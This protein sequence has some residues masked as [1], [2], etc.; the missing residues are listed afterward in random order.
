MNFVPDYKLVPFGV[1][2]FEEC[3]DLLSVQ[4]SSANSIKSPI[5]IALDTSKNDFIEKERRHLSSLMYLPWNVVLVDRNN[6]EI[7]G[8]SLL[9]TKTDKSEKKLLADIMD[10]YL[11]SHFSN[12]YK[13]FRQSVMND[14]NKNN[15][16]KY[17][18][19]LY[20]CVN[21]KYASK[22]VPDILYS[23]QLILLRKFGYSY[24][25][26]SI[27]NEYAF[28]CDKRYF[29]NELIV[30][31]QVKYTKISDYLNIDYK[32][33]NNNKSK[34]LNQAIKIHPFRY[35]GHM[36]LSDTNE[37]LAKFINCYPNYQQEIKSF[38][39]KIFKPCHNINQPKSKL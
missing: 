4:F 32:R 12:E 10:D 16:N 15:N 8:I 35:Y 31:V 20:T 23:Y 7:V 34:L 30:D 26:T 19:A 17:I 27:A 22:G 38:L 18:T 6:N 9:T 13:L 33:S 29:G 11:K 14:N 36:N 39:S 24:V 3:L 1:D 25:F 21:P 28:K 5:F 37:S 2:N